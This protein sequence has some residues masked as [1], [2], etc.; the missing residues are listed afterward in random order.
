MQYPDQDLQVSG[1]VKHMGLWGLGSQQDG[2]VRVSGPWDV[3]PLF[4]SSKTCCS[5]FIPGQRASWAL[6]LGLWGE[7]FRLLRA[8]RTST[9]KKGSNWASFTV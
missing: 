3:G 7:G 9:V 5:F 8:T 6:G 4:S 1:L 2:F